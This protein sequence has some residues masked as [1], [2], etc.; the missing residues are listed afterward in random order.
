MVERARLAEVHYSD[1]AGDLAR[2][3]DEPADIAI[4]S[5]VREACDGAV[6]QLSE[7]DFY[8]L[9][10]FARRGTVRAL[11]D[12]D[13]ALARTALRAL[14]LVD[15]DRIDFRDLSVDLPLYALRELGAD[16]N[17]EINQAVAR[18]T[19][20]T[21]KSF[22]AARGRAGVISLADCGM[23]EIETIYGV[24]LIEDWTGSDPSPTSLAKAAVSISDL[25]DQ[26]GTYR[27]GGLHVSE[28]P[29]IWVGQQEVSFVGTSGCVSFGGDHV[30]STHTF[31]HTLLVFLAE[32]PKVSEADRLA[33]A[34]TGSTTPDRPRAAI[35]AGPRLALFIG[36]SVTANEDAVETPATLSR[37][38]RLTATVL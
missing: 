8:K 19:P 34:A 38:T 7:D 33:K 24:G 22:K 5:Y 36:G 17:E 15:R 23:V 14:T 28:L 21:A 20:G 29:G 12:R 1:R 37:F 30:R 6:A 3:R 4:A 26:E 13:L 27:T 35:A 9:L 11:R 2:L 25:I 18:S 32:L 16:V 31:S 10:L